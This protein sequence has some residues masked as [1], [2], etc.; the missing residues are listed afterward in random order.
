[1][2]LKGDQ[3]IEVLVILEAIQLIGF[4]AFVRLRYRHSLRQMS[5]LTGQ[6]ATGQRPKSYYIDGPPLV[7][8]V[9]RHLESVGARL[10]QLQVRQQGEDFNLTVL[11]ANMVGGAM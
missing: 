5:R 11:L 6:L 4:W 9:S 10:E 8:Q 3:L 2:E 7:E 1:M